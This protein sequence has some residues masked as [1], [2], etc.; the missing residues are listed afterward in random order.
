MGAAIHRSSLRI[1]E[2]TWESEGLDLRLS[3]YLHREWA[4]GGKR[5]FVERS[6]TQV[7]NWLVRKVRMNYD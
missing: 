2:R 1:M 3:P 6:R 7:N 4:L 5:L